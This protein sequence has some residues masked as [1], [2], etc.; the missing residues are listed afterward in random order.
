MKF[1]AELCGICFTLHVSCVGMI[2]KRVLAV[3]LE[4][5]SKTSAADHRR[6]ETNARDET[7]TNL[8][9]SASCATVTSSTV[10]TG[11]SAGE[12]AVSFKSNVRDGLRIIGASPDFRDL[13]GP[14]PVGQNL[15]DCFRNGSN[16]C[17]LRVP[18]ARTSFFLGR[19]NYGKRVLK[20]PT[21]NRTSGDYVAGTGVVNSV[22]RDAACVLYVYEAAVTS[23]L[24]GG[25]QRSARGIIMTARIMSPNLDTVTSDLVVVVASSMAKEPLK[26][27]EWNTCHVTVCAV[28]VTL[29]EVVIDM[30]TARTLV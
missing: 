8:E 11:S 26:Y 2:P 15:A 25:L 13:S 22:S 20:S 17:A 18:A 30:P 19:R 1:N 28:E 10:S 6:T 4:S 9:T 23:V 29:A 27:S 12:V 14:I 21:A 3:W 24:T 5:T 7:H 16:L